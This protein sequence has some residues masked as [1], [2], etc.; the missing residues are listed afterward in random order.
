MLTK[1]QIREEFLKKRKNNHQPPSKDS[2]LKNLLDSS[3]VNHIRN[4]GI[5]LP[6]NNEVPT[7]SLIQYFWD[8]NI[9]CYLPVITPQQTLKFC[10]YEK[11]TYLTQ[12]KYNILEPLHHISS[13]KLDTIVIP[14]VAFDIKG[15]RIGMGKAYYD[16]TL[17]NMKNIFL[18]GLGFEFQKYNEIPSDSWDIKLNGI[19]TEKKL[20][21]T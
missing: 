5:Y 6:I 10:K 15:N 12:N 3:I 2:F 14:L 20:Y 7:E 9:S 8:K 19:L 11:N 1:S 21:L 17:I 16:R 18:L 4:V 13:S